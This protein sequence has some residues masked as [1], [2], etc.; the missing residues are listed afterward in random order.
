MQ[1]TFNRR[2]LLNCMRQIL[3]KNK[4]ANKNK[5]NLLIIGKEI[6][7]TATI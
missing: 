6:D 5:L 1:E 2:E 7:K 3:S 4:K